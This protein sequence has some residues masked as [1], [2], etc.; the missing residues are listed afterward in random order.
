[1]RI[2]LTT[3]FDP[4]A[5]VPDVPQTHARVCRVVLLEPASGTPALR[6]LFERG[7]LDGR[8]TFVVGARIGPVEIV[9]RP[10][11]PPGAVRGLPESTA[12]T[13]LMAQ[14]TL[15]GETLGDALRRVLLEYAA[16]NVAD[17]D[18]SVV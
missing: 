18:G 11:P 9:D 16:A 7:H 5:A 12:Y 2:E 3:P 14:P 13:D 17:L 4:R 10:A 8:G 15:D 1:M 6:A